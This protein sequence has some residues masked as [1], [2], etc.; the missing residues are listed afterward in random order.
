MSIFNC[1]LN[2]FF[3]KFVD[4][5]CWFNFTHANK[6]LKYVLCIT[7]LHENMGCFSILLHTVFIQCLL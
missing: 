6:S 2:E 7:E 3:D 1:K 5:V 4:Y